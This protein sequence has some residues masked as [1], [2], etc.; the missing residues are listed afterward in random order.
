MEQ[1]GSE[2][3]KMDERSAVSDVETWKSMFL[4]RYD[5]TLGTGGRIVLPSKFSDIIGNYYDS[6]VAA[7]Y[8]FKDPESKKVVVIPVKILAKWI[9][10]IRKHMKVSEQAN[11]YFNY[12]SSFLT[13]K[14]DEKQGRLV[15][16]QSLRNGRLNK[17]IVI[18]GKQDHMVIWDKNFYDDQV[19]LEQAKKED[20]VKFLQDTEN[21]DILL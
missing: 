6:Q 18:L 1:N 17:E 20:T 12:L 4:G 2:W 8:S 14:F 19:K 15:V 7:N 5:Q 21:L 13:P 3:K 11:L 9:A 16:P 10:G